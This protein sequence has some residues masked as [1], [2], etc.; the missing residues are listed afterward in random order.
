MKGLKTE[1]QG[2]MMSQL[3]TTVDRAIRLALVQQEIW[4]KGGRVGKVGLGNKGTTGGKVD[5]K[6]VVEQGCWSKER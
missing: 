4:A 6:V 1:I 2:P 5:P 3:P